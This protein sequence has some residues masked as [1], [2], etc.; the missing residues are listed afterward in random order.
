MG[1]AVREGG[2]E[3]WRGY[4][5]REGEREDEMEGMCGEG[6][7][8]EGEE[9]ESERGVKRKGGKAEGKDGG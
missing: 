7:D 8:V 4:G 6:R 3:R 9:V 5:G 1:K 2:R